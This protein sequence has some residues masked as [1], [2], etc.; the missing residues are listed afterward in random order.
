MEISARPATSRY[1]PATPEIAARMVAVV[2]HMAGQWSAVDQNTAFFT[3]ASNIRGRLAEG[4]FVEFASFQVDDAPVGCWVLTN[5][6]RT[7]AKE[8]SAVRYTWE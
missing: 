7:A 5:A 4:P 6:G 8:A 1:Q 2:L 3:G